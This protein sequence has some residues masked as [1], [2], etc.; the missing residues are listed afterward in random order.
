MATGDMRSSVRQG[1]RDAGEAVARPGAR[2]PRD[3]QELHKA[4][5]AAGRFAR[6]LQVLLRAAKLYQK[7]HPHVMESLEAAERELRGAFERVSPLELRFEKAR[8]LFRSQPLPDP[9]DD[10]KK[11]AD[12]VVRRG[13]SILVFLPH[14]HLGELGTLA[15]LIGNSPLQPGRDDAPD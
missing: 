11:L 8:V 7:N 14:A 13:I 3:T 4:Q 1:R 10:L 12:S 6:A 15:Q 9:R 5:I 2:S